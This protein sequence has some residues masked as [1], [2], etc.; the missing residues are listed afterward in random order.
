MSFY[1]FP[2]LTNLKWTK[3]TVCSLD[4]F[5]LN[6]IHVCNVEQFFLSSVFFRIAFLTIILTAEQYHVCICICI[7][8]RATV[9]Y[10]TAWAYLQCKH[11]VLF[12]QIHSFLSEICPIVKI[13]TRKNALRFKWQLNSFDLFIF[14]WDREK[15]T[16]TM[17][18]NHD[19]R[20]LRAYNLVLIDLCA[21]YYIL[22]RSLNHALVW[23]ARFVGAM[24]R[25]VVVLYNFLYHVY[26]Q[27]MP[28]RSIYE[29][30]N[31][32]F[33]QSIL[34]LIFFCFI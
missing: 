3:H 20:F 2:A 12:T 28:Y 17:K 9:A 13:C 23:S 33:F 5:R 11:S 31:S 15:F 16:N 19:L 4:S 10:T 6:S 26:I 1:F 7:C 29:K 22:C 25:P 18:N 34:V 30:I 32:Y 8:M 21:S 24:V 14:L 27:P